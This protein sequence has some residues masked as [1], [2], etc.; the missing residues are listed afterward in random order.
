MSLETPVRPKTE[1][2]GNRV[3]PVCEIEGKTIDLTIFGDERVLCA[4]FASVGGDEQR[5]HHAEIR[6]LMGAGTGPNLPLSTTLFEGALTLSVEPHG[7]SSLVKATNCTSVLHVD[8]FDPVIAAK[9]TA[10]VN[11]LPDL[12]DDQRREASQGL[13]DLAMR[14]KATNAVTESN[15]EPKFVRIPSV[16]LQDGRR[17]EMTTSGFA[18]YDPANHSTACEFQLE[19]SDGK[20]YIPLVDQN[21]AS[22][23]GLYLPTGVEEYNGEA[24]LNADVARFIERYVDVTDQDRAI[25]A[26]YVL[27]SY[28]ADALFEIPYLRAVGDS[29]NGKT[30]FTQAVG[31]LCCRPIFTVGITPAVLYRLND[32]YKP[33]LI[34]DEFNLQSRGE[35]TE[36]II[37][38]LNAGISRT[39]KV[40]RCSG[41]RANFE[42]EGFDPFGP[43]ILAGL[44]GT[45]SQPFESRTHPVRLEQTKRND[46]RIQLTQTMLEE[47]TVIRNKLTLW[48]LRTGG[49]DLSDNLLRAEDELKEAGG[50]RKRY[51]QVTIPL[52]ALISDQDVKAKFVRQ[53]QA[54]SVEYAED[55]KATS[56]GNLVDVIHSRL[57]VESGNGETTYLDYSADLNV[58]D[59]GKPDE[60]LTVPA[61]VE[62][63]NS[64]HPSKYPY[65]NASVGKKLSGLGLR[66]AQIQRRQSGNYKKRA[67]VW[68]ETRLCNLFADYNLP[69]PPDFAVRT[70]RS[71]VSPIDT[72]PSVRTVV[73][74]EDNE[75]EQLFAPQVLQE[76]E[77]HPCEQCEQEISVADVVVGRTVALD[78]ET[79]PFDKKRGITA[80]NARMIGMSLSY[81][82]ENADYHS[83]PESWP[84]FL[85]EQSDTIIFHNAKFDIGVLQRS[86]LRVPARFEDT[87]I[88]ARLINENVP[89][90]LKDLARSHLGITDPLT[91]EEA[92]RMRLLDPEVFSEYARNDARYTFALWEKLEPELDRQDLRKVY[93][94][95]KKL[96]PL[97]LEMERVGMKLDIPSLR[98]IEREVHKEQSRLK[99]LI[100]AQVGCRFDTGS[101]VAVGT[102][103]YDTLGLKCPKETAKGGR[104]VSKDTLTELAHPVSNLLLE[105]R[106]IDKLANAFIRTLPKFADDRGRIHPEF[107]PLGAATGRF[108]CAAPNVQQIPGKSELGKLVRRAF[109]AEKG[110]K[111]V[112]AD[113]SQM[114]LRILAHY[115]K[116]PLLMA[117]YNAETPVDL[118]TLTAQRV[119]GRE[120]ITGDERAIAK[121][122]NFGISYGVTAAGLFRNLTAQ[123]IQTTIAECESMIADYFKTYAGVADFLKEV[124]SV[125]RK[126]KYVRSISG[127]R[128]RFTAIGPREVRQAQ[129]FVI[130]GTSA[131]LCKTAMVSLYEPL[132]QGANLISMIHDELIVEC[133]EEQAEDVKAIVE[134]VMQTVP[135]GFEVPMVVDAKIVDCWADAK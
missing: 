121:M 98:E 19:D 2:N 97:I 28:R 46:I 34:I 77:L 84:L 56:D 13:L 7:R 106:S 111:L 110:H 12:D 14:T 11:K 61:I 124:E 122:M 8:T 52:Y 135:E 72:I 38:L 32:I 94:L 126:R 116:D 63:M 81:D 107:K 21:E 45:D 102:I 42:P 60:R 128:R 36:A 30:R 17:A 9:R 23:I 112:V 123:G 73:A 6:K 64:R 69:V 37:Q 43:K 67:V 40:I 93:E 92:D 55:K 26:K 20:V 131:D 127:R 29:G 50:I 10:F 80:R 70:V 41:D 103:L 125:V 108:S 57:F 113:Y 16:V 65:T 87:L 76:V 118:H 75:S 109:I 85:P 79:E 101:N 82:G 105:L 39:N 133:R 88:A 114:E 62:D 49:Q 86:G 3:C 100:F 59:E 1:G 90:G 134:A 47:A 44:K 24:Q 74:R 120:E 95:E 35:D 115:S 66:T 54:R 129:N 51:I 53:L 68:D 130:Q 31:L 48:K 96:V 58:R 117:A 33:T 4:R 27:M 22:K 132:P 18:V 104:S 25:A 71:D 89:N 15:R 119:F 83:E 91:F 5:R 78:T 99:E